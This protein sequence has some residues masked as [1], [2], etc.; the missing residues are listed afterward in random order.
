MKLINRIRLWFRLFFHGLFFGLRAADQT[1]TKQVS[2]DD[3]E[4]NHR[5]EL[6]NVFND[7]LQENE[8]Q[9]VQEMRDKNYRVYR[10]A[11]KYDI[12]VT[13]MKTDGENFD[14]EDSE[15]YASASKKVFSDKPMTNLLETRNYKITLVQDV[16]EYENDI[17][18]KQ[19]ESETGEAID[20][21]ST[22]IFEITYKD[23]IIP[24]FYIERYINRVVLKEND[25]GSYR[26]DLYFSQYAR[27]FM[28]RDSLFIAE[29]HRVFD[30]KSPKSDILAV[31]SISFITDKAFGSEDLHRITLRNFTYKKMCQYDGSFVIEFACTKDDED[32]VAK[33]RT[34]E[35]DEKYAT[36]AQKK[37]VVDIS[38]MQRKIER[39]EQKE[40]TYEITTLK[41]E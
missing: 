27:Q 10:E 21:K 14:D 2:G 4:I 39:D 1:L 23:E 38:A 20:D 26:V 18:T 37:Q 8:T 25:N 12:T 9:Q 30:G 5:L 13:G 11:N 6:D 15:L 32:V 17:V 7:M 19:K 34:K 35:L 36:E 41:I 28:K 29:L 40:K 3:D 16:K 31:D 24:R 33:Y 22:N